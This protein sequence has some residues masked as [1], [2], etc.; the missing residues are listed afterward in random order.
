MKT[1]RLQSQTRLLGALA[2]LT[3]LP[4]YGQGTFVNLNFEDVIPTAPQ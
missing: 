1:T 2:L 4:L 3:W